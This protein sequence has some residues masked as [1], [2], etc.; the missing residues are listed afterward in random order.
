[1][2]RQLLLTIGIILFTIGATLTF[3][4]SKETPKEQTKVT[5]ELKALEKELDDS[6]KELSALQKEF[7]TLQQVKAETEQPV[8]E[9]PKKATTKIVITIED[10]VRSPDVAVSL[11]EAN[12]ID[13]AQKF[14]DFLKEK[15]YASKIQLG[16]YEIDP[17]MDY[18]AIAK[19]ITQQVK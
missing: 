6:K 9:E 13:D 18:E 4:P 11:A 15:G 5:K 3:A 2:I 7:E 16:T 1:M 12:I 10:G 19:I 17:T 8:E 14:N